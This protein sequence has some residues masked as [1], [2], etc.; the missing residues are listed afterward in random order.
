MSHRDDLYVVHILECIDKINDFSRGDRGRFL[1]EVIVQDAVLRNL[2]TLAE[3]TK[4]LSDELKDSMPDIRW[5]SVAGFRNLIVHDYLGV[6]AER[7][8]EIVEQELPLLEKALRV[9]APNSSQ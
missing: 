5:E 3:S 2:Q 1:A 4:R 7:V 6:N 9:V 8:W